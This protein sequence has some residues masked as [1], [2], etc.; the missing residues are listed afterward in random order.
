MK[1]DM[2]L[3]RAI[4]LA[5]EAGKAIGPN[6]P[7]GGY[8]DVQVGYHCYLLADAGLAIGAEWE[9]DDGSHYPQYRI[10]YLT[11]TGHEFL[12]LSRNQTV[13]KKITSTVKEKTGALAFDMVKAALT[14][15]AS[16]AVGKIDFT[17]LLQ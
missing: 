1:R 5:L 11:W 13:W 15:A 3:C 6:E 9:C 14:A 8:D 12:D 17:A 7:L 10:A 16:G 4:L 2:D